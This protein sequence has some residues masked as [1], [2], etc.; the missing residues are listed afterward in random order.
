MKIASVIV[1]AVVAVVNADELP[2]E[3]HL[4]PSYEFLLQEEF[5]DQLDYETNE[6]FGSLLRIAARVGG[7]ALAKGIAKGAAKGIAKG[8]AKGAAKGIAKG[9]AKGI[10]KGAAKGIAKGAAKGITKG[11]VKGV[12]RGTVK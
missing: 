4:D 2:A 7:R 11:A 5:V 3:L 1:L 12:V 10:A 8:V 9:A 6:L